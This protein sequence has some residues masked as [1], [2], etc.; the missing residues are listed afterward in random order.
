[1]LEFGDKA[2]A[3]VRVC[4]ATVHE[5]VH[6]DLREVHLGGFRQEF[7][8]VVEGTVH[9]AVRAEAHEVQLLAGVGHVGV[10][11][12]DL[13]VLQEAVAAAGAVDFHQVLVDD[14]ATA[15]VE[16]SHFR[17]AHLPLG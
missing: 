9:T 6:E 8:E 14:A 1:M 4:V 11:A 10:G 2:L 5:A 13:L 16:V 12:A 7:V 15:D 17:I 3:A